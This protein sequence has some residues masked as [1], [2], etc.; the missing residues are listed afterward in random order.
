MPF[1]FLGSGFMLVETK[2]I[3]EL[4]LHLGGTWYVIAATIVLVLVMAFFANFIVQRKMFRRTDF[5]Y[6][7]LLVSLLV[8]YISARN[9]EL[10]ALSSPLASLI[11]SCVLL[12]IPLF[13]SGIVF[14][15]LIGKANINISTALAY[16]LMGALFG[17][18]M[19][20]NSMYFGFAFLYLLAIGF[21]FLAWIFS[22][23]RAAATLAKPGFAPLVKTM[24]SQIRSFI[25]VFGI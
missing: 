8:G 10:I 16:N 19:E 12:T 13:F 24:A 2:A 17:G 7:G 14:S 5:A 6:L 15:S 3:T 23:D 20:Y 18:L 21:Y 11:V 4:G 22:W 25:A 9:H 1:F